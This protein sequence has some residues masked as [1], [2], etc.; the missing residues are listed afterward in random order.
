MNDKF[1]RTLRTFFQAFVGT[2]STMAIPVL[3]DI[4]KA[5]GEADGETVR[6]NVNF[7]GY[8][9]IACV[10][11]GVISLITFAQNALEDTTGKHLL[12]K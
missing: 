8:I 6:V 10:V 1:R 3:Y 12:P 2:L 9:L 5:A 4:M 7:L 11:A